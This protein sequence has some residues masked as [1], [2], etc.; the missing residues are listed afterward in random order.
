MPSFFKRDSKKNVGR[1]QSSSS[2]SN[3]AHPQ[4]PGSVGWSNS[5]QDSWGVQGNS[6][7]IGGWSSSSGSGRP[8]QGDLHL[9]VQRPPSAGGF[10]NPGLSPSPGGVTPPGNDKHPSGF[11]GGFPPPQG[12]PP[13]VPRDAQQD[14]IYAWFVA[15]DQDG[16]GEISPQELQSAL[17]GDGGLKFS[18]STVNYLMS[19][20]DLDNSRGIGFQEFES[21]WGYIT[22]WRQMFESFDIDRN[23]KIDADELG[24]AL[25]HYDL[26]VGLPVLDKLVQKYASTSPRSRGPQYGPPAPPQINLDQFV[27][28]CVIVQQMCRLYDQCSGHGSAQISRD[29]FIRAVISLP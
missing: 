10:I 28:A 15:V 26:R 7:P 5:N 16:S 6:A 13:F 21:L 2:S 8:S 22:Q 14:E 17:I 9:Q 3:N 1:F 11:Q 18:S 23:G 4:S 20:F 29:D 12:P 19:I 24:R 27:C 25:A